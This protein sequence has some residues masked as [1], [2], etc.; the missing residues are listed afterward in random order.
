M[1]YFHVGPSCRSSA[2][3]TALGQSSA[4][5]SPRPIQASAT[6]AADS[7]TSR[8]LM[9]ST[10]SRR[11]EFGRVGQN[12][13]LAVAARI[14]GVGRHA[15][16]LAQQLA[17]LFDNEADLRRIDLGHRALARI[18][19]AHWAASLFLRI[20]GASAR[21]TSCGRSNNRGKAERCHE[22][23]VFAARGCVLV[24]ERADENSRN[25]ACARDRRPADAIILQLATAMIEAN[26]PSSASRVRIW[27][28]PKSYSSSSRL[29]KS[30]HER[31]KAERAS[32]R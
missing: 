6:R 14:G 17:R 18:D 4:S 25:R 5:K 15:D 2:A 23:A 30:S 8:S 27:E 13:A 11:I 24:P 26:T 21:L 10:S 16:V 12:D 29:W 20:H 19:S 32:S 22:K 31:S 7:S 9:N 28:P 1:R 3:A